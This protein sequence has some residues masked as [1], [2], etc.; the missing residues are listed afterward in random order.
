MTLALELHRSVSRY[1]LARA[2]GRRVPGLLSGPAAPLRLVDTT[3]TLPSGEGWA[4]I[5][6]RLSGICGSDLATLSGH[7]SFYFEPLVSFPFVLG[8]EI[9]GDL[10]DPSDDLPSGTRVVI[11]P[12]LSCS[13]RGLRPCTAC[14]GGATNR[15]NRVTAGHIA[16]GIQTGYCA[17]TGGGWSEMLVA[18]RSQMHPIPDSLPDERAV[19]IEPLACALHAVLRARVRAGD[20]ALVTGA[21]TLGLLTVVAL[22]AIANAARITVV[23]KHPHQKQLARDLGADDAVAPDEAIAA[24][25]RSHKSFLLRPRSGSN[26]LLG[27]VEVAFECAGTKSALDLCLRATGAGGCVA[28]VGLP[29]GGVDLTPVWFRELRLIGAY[30]SATETVDGRSKHTIDMAVELAGEIPLEK[31]IGAL[32]PLGAWR[33]GVDHALDAGRLGAT[34]IVFD[35]RGKQGG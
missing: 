8:H 35:L 17:Q 30:A 22:K 9:V 3:A 26:F 28:L 18:H 31:L 4:R 34:K 32:Y 19:L 16:A 29:S 24:I 6:P 27:G 33:R 5:R 25:R 7:S 2:A 12:V 13:A 21:G 11:D 15:C 10:V 23:A 20:S 1:A 14:A